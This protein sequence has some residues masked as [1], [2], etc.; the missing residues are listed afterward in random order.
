MEF[1]QCGGLLVIHDDGTT[2]CLEPDCRDHDQARH[3]WR[4]DCGSCALCR[5]SSWAFAPDSLD[6][7]QRVP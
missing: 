6:L 4:S 3:E 2:E 1:D 5:L 7:D